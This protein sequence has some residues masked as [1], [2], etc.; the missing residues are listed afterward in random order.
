MQTLTLTLQPCSWLMLM[1]HACELACKLD[2]VH[3][4][5]QEGDQKTAKQSFIS[6]TAL[7]QSSVMK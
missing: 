5:L 7:V 2:V 3:A 1:A 4:G 6:G